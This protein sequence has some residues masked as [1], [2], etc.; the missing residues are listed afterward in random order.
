MG[1]DTS[2]QI[3]VVKLFAS[4]A[5]PALQRTL[6]LGSI[7][8]RQYDNRPGDVGDTVNVP[9]PP[10]NVVANDISEGDNV[11]TQQ[12]SL[13]N[14]AIVVNKHKESSF[15]V[16]DVAGLLTNLDLIKTY[17]EPAVISVAEQIEADLFSNYANFTSG[18][19]GAQGTPLTSAVIGSAETALYGARAYGEKYLALTPTDYD[20]VR[21]LPEFSEL[22]KIGSDQQ[23]SQALALGVVGKIKGFN[24]F[25]SQLT[26][27]VTAGS[28][29]VTT[30]YNIAFTPDAV[31]LVTRPFKAIP[32]G[33]GAVSSDIELGNFKMQLVWS[34]NPN[35]LAQQFTVHCLYGVKTLRPTFGVQVKS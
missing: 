15:T 7:V 20:V 3:Q 9:V 13:G 6:Q 32:Q 10:T 31:A 14:V 23:V 16:T 24:A 12:T 28:P 18:P 4:Q 26:P 30:N 21:A 5:L 29:A 25:R 11:Q 8:N 34:Y 17:L 1:F 35:A 27:S 33:I 19:V 2:A 22:A